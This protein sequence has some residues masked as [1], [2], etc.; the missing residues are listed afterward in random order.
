[1]YYMYTETKIFSC[2]FGTKSSWSGTCYVVLA[3]NRP[4]VAVAFQA[5]GLGSILFEEAVAVKKQH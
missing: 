1:M 5:L 4:A 2:L 3:S